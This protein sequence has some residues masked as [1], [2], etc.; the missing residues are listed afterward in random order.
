[1]EAKIALVPS[2]V[3]TGL[4][5]RRYG[6][7]LTDSRALFVLQ[8]SLSLPVLLASVGGGGAAGAI[9]ATLANLGGTTTALAFAIGGLLG[10]GVAWAG[11]RER[12]PDYATLDPDQLAGRKGALAIPYGSIHALVLEKNSRIVSRLWITYDASAGMRHELRAL[13]L[14]DARWVRSRGDSGVKP[15]EAYAEYTESVRQALVRALPPAI[16]S[17]VGFG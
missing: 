13:L 15:R 3:V 9:L 4:T 16:A 12:I 5:Q 7:M 1:M 11:M 14:P 2:V 8:R 17:K 10:M 6:L